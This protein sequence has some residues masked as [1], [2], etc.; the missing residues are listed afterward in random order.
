MNPSRIALAIGDPNGIGPEIAVKAAV[1]PETAGARPLLIGDAFVIRHYVGQI[2]PEWRVRET[3]DDARAEDGVIEVFPVAA[4][5]ESDFEP[6]RVC[7]AAGRATVDYVRAAINLAEAGRVRAIVACP[8][9]ETAVNAAG[10]PFTGYPELVAE[11]RGLPPGRVFMMFVGGGLRIVH[12]TLHEQLSGALKRLTPELVEAAA[13]AGVEALRTLGI[14]KPKIGLFGVNPH[15]GEGGLFG[16]NDD[17]VTV[18]AAAALRAKGVDVEGPIGAD[19]L[20]GRKDLDAFV[21][22]YHD[23]GH[24]PV[25]LLAGRKA[26]ALSIGAGLMFSTVGHGSAHDIAGRNEADPEAVLR[27]LALLGGVAA[28]TA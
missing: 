17:R 11:L 7:A 12:A 26:S 9:N 27:T 5:A 22:M 6:G 1:A 10:I 13:L 28:K 3:D 4:L 18:P 23:Q 19:L 14:A 2:A 15:A 16:D 20:I 24:I 21:A 25:K 8:H